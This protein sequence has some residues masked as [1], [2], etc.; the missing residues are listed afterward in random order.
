MRI[1]FDLIENLADSVRVIVGLIS[2]LIMGS[3]LIFTFGASYVATGAVEDFAATAEEL[4]KEAIK[5][6]RE[7]ERSDQLAKEGWGFY[8]DDAGSG[9]DTVIYDELR[10]SG[11]TADRWGADGWNGES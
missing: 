4:G 5:A 10:A 7:A 1:F 11:Y 3:A 6:Q 2:V 8:S 9:D